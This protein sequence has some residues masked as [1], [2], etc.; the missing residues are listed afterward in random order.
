MSKSAFSNEDAGRD[1]LRH[2]DPKNIEDRLYDVVHLSPDTTDELLSTVDVPLKVG[3]DPKG[4]NYIL[5]DYNRDCDSYRF[6]GTNDYFPKL[7]DGY[8]LPED[9]IQ[10]EV[11]ANR[12][13]QSYLK[14]YFDY[15]ILSVY[16]WE[17]DDNS[18]GVGVFV[19]KDVQSSL[20]NSNDI[21]GLISCCDVFE[22]KRINK[23]S[24]QYQ[25]T[26][27]SSALLD[28]TWGC[29]ALSI[30]ECKPVSLSGSVN[31]STT[32]VA[33]A[34]SPLAHL[35]TIGTMIE[36]NAD[37]FVEKIRQIYVAKMKEILSYMKVDPTT[38]VSQEAQDFVADGLKES[39]K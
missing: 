28:V 2:V 39:S 19:R 37:R 13:F 8:P 36:E 33:F 5:C 10:L 17:I 3:T 1:L 31:S 11:M 6:P 18:F 9:L 23:K 34:D 20:R 22:V 29:S 15:G 16:C 21:S 12:G 24:M 32:Q 38:T 30:G 14:Q 26:L 4:R 25:Y 35:V 27:V 7:S